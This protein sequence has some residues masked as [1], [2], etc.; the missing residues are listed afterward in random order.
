MGDAAGAKC[1]TGYLTLT[2]EK[3]NNHVRYVKPD[4]SMFL[5]GIMFGI[6]SRITLVVSFVL[7]L[8]LVLK[9][10]SDLTVA[11]IGFPF[12]I[13]R[14]MLGF[15]FGI[16]NWPMMLVVSISAGVAFVARTRTVDWAEVKA[17][18]RSEEV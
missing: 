9:P 18:F 10:T 2:K 5:G 3:R 6:N 16:I 17:F 11:I 12:V 8:L 1:L 15:G 7:C 14:K 13:V 4:K